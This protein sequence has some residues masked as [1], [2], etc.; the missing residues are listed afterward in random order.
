VRLVI[1]RGLQGIE[2]RLDPVTA[3]ERRALETCEMQGEGTSG[4]GVD[5]IARLRA[6][7]KRL[8]FPITR[9]V[10]LPPARAW[11]AVVQR[12]ERDLYARLAPMA[13]PDVMMIWDRRQRDRRTGD[14]PIPTDQ[15]RGDR[16]HPPPP[17]WDTQRFLLVRLS[18]VPA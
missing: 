7:A 5:A 3:A 4:R 11:L 6:L 15:R 10:E 1:T 14:Q 18:D 16:R 8:G 13:G 2:V 9:P 17:T 12:G